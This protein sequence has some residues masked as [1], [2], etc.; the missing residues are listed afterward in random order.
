MVPVV[1]HGWK[2]GNPEP[3]DFQVTNIRHVFPVFT[4]LT[5]ST[6]ACF[7]L[8]MCTS[9]KLYT[10]RPVDFYKVSSNPQCVD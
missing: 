3:R 5:S 9:Y 10:F 8:Y 1:N 7:I 4:I 2:T 6:L